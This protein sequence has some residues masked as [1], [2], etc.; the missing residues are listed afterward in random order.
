VNIL[1]FMKMASKWMAKTSPLGLLLVGTAVVAG[2]PVVTNALRGIAVTA[3][4]GVLTLAEGAASLGANVKEGW[5][6]LVAEAKA[7]KSAAGMPG[8][9]TMDMGTVVGAGAGGAVGASIGGSMAGA[10]GA[11]VGAG[12]GSVVGAG[13]GSGV[14]E[15]HKDNHQPAASHAAEKKT[16]KKE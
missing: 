8:A 15:P 6:D 1:H 5:E 13:V 9:E 7:Q 3:T 10:M 16:T 11:A 12:V 4:R 2:A 14:T